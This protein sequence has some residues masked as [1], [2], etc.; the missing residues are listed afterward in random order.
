MST[1]SERVFCKRAA[2][3]A[4]Q[5]VYDIA[6]TR[7]IEHAAQEGLEPGTLMRRAG[8]AIARLALALSPHATTIW[9]PCGP[10]NNG[11]DGYAAALE[12]VRLG[13]QPIVTQ[14]PIAHPLSTD[15]QRYR[16]Q[17]LAVGVQVL[18]TIPA[19]FELCIDAMFGIGKCSHFD[20]TSVAWIQA[21]N[22]SDAT[23][24]SVDGPTGLNADTGQA[25][26][27][28]VRADHTLSLLT[29]KP[30]FFTAD[31]QDHCGD[32]W[33]NRLGVDL[34]NAAFARLGTL[35]TPVSRREN[36]H[37]G[38]YGDVAVIG[39]GDGMLG[40]AA[41]CAKAALQSGAGRVYVALLASN[42]PSLDVCQPELMFRRIQ[43]L[44]LGA[45]VTVA[46]CGAGAA[47]VAC[48]DDILRRARSL[49]L[50][51]DAL[52]VLAQQPMSQVLLSERPSQTT[53][54]TPHPLE[55]ARLLGTTVQQVQANRFEAAQSIAD[56][57]DCVVVLKGS[58]TIIA[59]KG[60]PPTIN[61]TG[62]PSLATA[63]TGDVL[64][65]LI[66]S[67]IACGHDVVTAAC[68]AVYHHGAMADGWP[69]PPPSLSASRLA[70]VL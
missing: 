38:T 5:R 53:V 47:M 55:A 52:N 29:L 22:A 10:G 51:A 34:P 17:A 40:A 21:I 32:V 50:D 8:A 16:D 48:I 39:G 15:F 66:G 25:S 30:G 61:T 70:G 37:K 7:N 9:I 63:G 6:T 2:G 41:L 14:L 23:V 64:A 45:C 24:L 43:D 65:G 62:G 3:S 36:S 28:A 4:G 35:Q 33:L 60:M 26:T 27:Y 11:G 18:P 20:A 57:W 54:L 67:Y 56:R 42:A 46:G 44:D 31:A 68:R 12:L 13:K 58:G 49:V 19:A 69:A 59:A 1:N